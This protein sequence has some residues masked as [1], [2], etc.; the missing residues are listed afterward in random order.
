MA[1]VTWMWLGNH[2]QVNAT[3]GTPST[4]IEADRLAGYGAVGTAQIKAV[5]LKGDTRTI[6][7]D[8]KRVEAFATTYNDDSMGRDVTDSRMTYDAP[9]SGKAVTTTITGFLSVRYQLTFPDGGTSKQDG[10]L[11]Q[12]KN[13]DMFFR[14][15]KDALPQ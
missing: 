8:G 14:P 7:V 13:G 11:I 12:M 5:T 9:S 4:E 3:N 10:V 2:A 6:T 15:S 1:L